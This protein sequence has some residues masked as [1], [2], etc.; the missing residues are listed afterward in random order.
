MLGREMAARVL[1]RYGNG[2]LKTI[3][4]GERLLVRVLRPWKARF[5]DFS[6]YPFI[7]ISD[8][9]STVHRRTIISHA[10]GHHFLHGDTNQIWL[11]GFDRVWNRRQEH[12]AEEFA[13]YLTI[14]EADEV[15]LPGLPDAEVARMYK[16]TEDLVRIRRGA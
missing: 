10:L 4:K 11:R 14:P 7:F 2:N 12:Q 1:E 9:I 8:G 3:A 15:W 6:V 5:Q 16:V 13:A